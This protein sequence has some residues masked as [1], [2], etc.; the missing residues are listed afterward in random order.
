MQKIINTLINESVKK[1]DI[2]Y[3][4]DS[5]WLIFTDRKEWVVELVE[6]DMLW[7]NYHFFAK[8]FRYVSLD[9]VENQHYITKWVEDTIMNGVKKTINANFINTKLAKDTIQRGIKTE[10]EAIN[11]IEYVED[12]IE[13]GV[14]HT[15]FDD[16]LPIVHI[17]N[18]IE[19]G[20]KHTDV[21]YSVP[22]S[23]IEDV[24]KKNTQPIFNLDK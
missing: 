11:I 8:L 10:F 2:Y 3:Y 17:T 12:V 6:S 18:A 7:Y 1:A 20:V 5:L 16:H 13:N 24:I 15:D 22:T 19:N 4:E 14:K 23:L 21:L 9:V